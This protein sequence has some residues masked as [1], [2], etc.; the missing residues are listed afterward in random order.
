[1]ANLKYNTV[2]FLICCL[3][4][5]FISSAVARQYRHG[6]FALQLSLNPPNNCAPRLSA[7]V[8]AMDPVMFSSLPFMVKG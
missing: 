1:M 6:L 7:D 4:L 5:D 8:Y 3:T 2:I